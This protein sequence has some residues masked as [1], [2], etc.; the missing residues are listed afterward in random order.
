MGQQVI[1]S[2]IPLGFVILNDISFCT[3]YVSTYVRALVFKILHYILLLCES[4]AAST[5]RHCGAKMLDPTQRDPSMQS[6]QRPFHRKVPSRAKTSTLLSTWN[7]CRVNVQH[8]KTMSAV[9]H[10]AI[11]LASIAGTF[12]IYLWIAPSLARAFMTRP[13]TMNKA[14]CVLRGRLTSGGWTAK[15]V[16]ACAKDAKICHRPLCQSLAQNPCFKIL[17][18]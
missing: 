14:S 11:T 2:Q 6:S 9:N 3:T 13:K 10:L 12:E 4:H 1:H 5:H 17:W 8:F 15:W 16:H 18:L 7:S